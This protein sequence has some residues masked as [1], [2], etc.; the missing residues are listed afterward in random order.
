MER[1]LNSTKDIILAEKI[2]SS[3]K[4]KN[5]DVYMSKRFTREDDLEDLKQ[6][7]AVT[8]DIVEHEILLLILSDDWGCH[9]L[10][11]IFSPFV[12]SIHNSQSNVYF[13]VTTDGWDDVINAIF[14]PLIAN[15]K[16]RIFNFTKQ[17]DY[18]N[19]TLNI[20]NVIFD[21]IVSSS[22]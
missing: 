5:F 4:E 7:H 18:D 21:D 17:D 1:N 11:D 6:Y 9:E 15:K 13:C 22:K 16:G 3:L 12:R 19:T 8:Y 14:K 2:K 20:V 10:Q